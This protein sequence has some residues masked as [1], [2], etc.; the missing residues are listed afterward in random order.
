M[1]PVSTR[2]KPQNH[3]PAPKGAS[4]GRRIAREKRTISAMVA[5]YC[6]HHHATSAVPCEACRTL[7]A[8]ARRRL[9]V[10]PFQE[11]KPA[12]NHCQ[13]HCY[14]PTMRERVKEVMRYAGPRMVLRHPVLSVYHLLDA[15][16]PAPVL[17]TKGS[18]VRPRKERDR[19]DSA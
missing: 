14:S 3:G 19:D 5:I 11:A 16:R 2:D 15:R 9:E 1:K 13:V 10:C 6:R 8:Y 4:E 17:G 12:C 18:R 7:L